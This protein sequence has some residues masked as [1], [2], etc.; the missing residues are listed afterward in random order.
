ML[1]TDMWDRSG[2]AP[3]IGAGYVRDFIVAVQRGSAPVRVQ[4]AVYMN[5]YNLCFEDGCPDCPDDPDKCCLNT[6]VDPG[7]A[8]TGWYVCEGIEEDEQY[9][10]LLQDGDVVLGWI[11]WPEWSERVVLS[12][13]MSRANLSDPE[14]DILAFFDAWLIEPGAH[15]EIDFIRIVNSCGAGSLKNVKRLRDLKFLSRSGDTGEWKVAPDADATGVYATDVSDPGPYVP[16]EGALSG[17]Y[18]TVSQLPSSVAGCGS[19]NGAVVG[20]VVVGDV[21]EVCGGCGEVLSG[22]EM[23]QYGDCCEKC[24]TADP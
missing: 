12:G 5:G 13:A 24:A 8:T 21:D 20:D 17:G 15:R 16:C 9:S 4:M 1:T 11:P 23:I 22:T 7:V 6:G 2:D 10:K 19:M 3:V 14:K 18:E